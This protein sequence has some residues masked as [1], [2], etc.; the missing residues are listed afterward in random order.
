[1]PDDTLD[2]YLRACDWVLMPYRFHEGSSG[3]LSGAAAAGRPGDRPRLRPDRQSRLQLQSRHCVSALVRRRARRAPFA[4]RAPCA[5]EDFAAAPAAIF[6]QPYGRGF[7]R[8]IARPAGTGAPQPRRQ[9]TRRGG[10]FS[11]RHGFHA[12]NHA[13]VLKHVVLVQLLA[14]MAA[15]EKAFSFVDTHAGAGSYSLGSDFARK[16]SEFENGIG[17]LWKADRLPAALE[18]YLAQVRAL[19]RDGKLHFY[20]GSPQIALQMMRP[21]DRLHLFELHSTESEVLQ[22]LFRQV[23]PARG[24]AGRG[25]LRRPEIGAAAAVAPGPGAHRSFLRGQAGLRQGPRHHAR[26]AQALRHRH[27]RGLVPA[28]AAQR[29]ASHGRRT[30]TA[31]QLATGCTYRSRSA[32]RRRTAWACTAAAC[33]SS[34]R[35]GTWKARCAK[36]CRRS[37]ACSARTA[38]DRSSCSSARPD[39]GRQGR[40]RRRAIFSTSVSATPGRLHGQTAMQMAQPCVSLK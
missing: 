11:Y 32:R 4:A 8:R 38:R 17:R 24:G 31:R 20:P 23:G 18:A 27:L 28:G 25:R 6:G 19:N 13:D 22:A 29:G 14:H 33:S 39:D 7:H 36:R 15:K 30:G 35:P 2:L 5:I 9:L 3:L 12:G 34:I 10:L 40:A 26:C 16:K 37:P 21:Q 1:M